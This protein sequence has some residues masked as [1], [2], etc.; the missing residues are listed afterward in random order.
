MSE[1]KSQAIDFN[2]ND[3]LDPAAVGADSKMSVWAGGKKDSG[4]LGDF[5]ELPYPFLS[6]GAISTSKG[7]SRGDYAIEVSLV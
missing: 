1:G 3:I 5:A 7:E 6:R 2:L 4:I